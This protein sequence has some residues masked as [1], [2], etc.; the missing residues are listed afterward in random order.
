MPLRVLKLKQR[1][2]GESDVAGVSA[3]LKAECTES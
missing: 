2:A 1:F 3:T